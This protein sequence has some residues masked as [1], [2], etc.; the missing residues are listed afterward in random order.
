MKSLDSK[1]PVKIHKMITITK[2]M[3]MKIKWYLNVYHF[4][5]RFALGLRN[6]ISSS[7]C[8]FLY[9]VFLFLCFF[10]FFQSSEGRYFPFVI[11]KFQ[12]ISKMYWQEKSMTCTMP[13]IPY[14]EEQ[15]QEWLLK[16]WKNLSCRRYFS[17]ATQS[18]KPTSLTRIKFMLSKIKWNDWKL[19]EK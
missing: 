9:S 6:I 3:H 16:Y 10:F 13:F 11:L 18:E 1:V 5:R 15:N 14:S 19:A 7:Y 4:S 8:L 2:Q 17:S 12:Y